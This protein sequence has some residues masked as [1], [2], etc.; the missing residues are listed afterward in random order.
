MTDKEIKALAVEVRERIISTAAPDD[1]IKSNW[2][3]IKDHIEW[4]IR[5]A[6]GKADQE[7]SQ[8]AFKTFA[9][10]QLAIMRGH[11]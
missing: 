7:E 11:K 10:E 2:N 4:G 3:R 1:S 5:Q 6:C 9:K 8:R